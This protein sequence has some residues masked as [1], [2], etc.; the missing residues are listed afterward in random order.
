MTWRRISRDKGPSSEA[1]TGGASPPR[2][3]TSGWRTYSS[4]RKAHWQK[5]SLLEFDGVVASRGAA[6]I[7]FAGLWRGRQ[8]TIFEILGD[9][10]WLAPWLDL[11]V[12]CH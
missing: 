5:C 12:L 3:A 8:L 10:L 2:R 7:C 6:R 9:K 1:G 11:W 4:F